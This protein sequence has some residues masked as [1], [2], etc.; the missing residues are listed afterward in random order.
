MRKKSPEKTFRETDMYTV[1]TDDGQRDLT[2]ETNL[3]RLEEKFSKL[4]RDKLDKRLP[5]TSEERVYLCMFA[6][7]MYGRTK[8]FAAHTSEQWGKALELGEKME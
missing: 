7:A 3:S 8:A 4:R 1:R 5:L 6:A 2:L